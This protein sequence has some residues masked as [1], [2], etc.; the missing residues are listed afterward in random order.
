[1][2][3]EDPGPS[4]PEGSTWVDTVA[5]GDSLKAQ[6]VQIDAVASDYSDDVGAAAS[7]DPLEV[8]C[9]HLDA[10]LDCDFADQGS[11]G[12]MG[13]SGYTCVSTWTRRIQRC[14]A[15]R[16]PLVLAQLLRVIP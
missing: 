15:L 5:S 1:M 12:F 16:V 11:S 6:C 2:G 9:V 7:G 10:A 4:C 13:G 14:L 3:S 8:H